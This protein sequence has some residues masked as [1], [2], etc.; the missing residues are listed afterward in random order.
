VL[1]EYSRDHS[2]KFN[3]EE[4]E[5]LDLINQGSSMTSFNSMYH[6]TFADQIGKSG[7][8]VISDLD[9]TSHMEPSLARF[10]RYAKIP[11]M[12]IKLFRLRQFFV[13]ATA[14]VEFY[15]LVKKRLIRY[16]IFVAE[17]V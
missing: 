17:K 16:R 7:F 9:I 2:D 4:S 14:G 5:I 13:N 10:Y 6:D 15:K 8:K 1:F 11:Y 12:F 3:R